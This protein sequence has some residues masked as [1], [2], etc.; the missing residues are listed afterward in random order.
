MGEGE[1]G[2]SNCAGSGQRADM[3]LNSYVLN[4]YVSEEQLRLPRTGADRLF[5]SVRLR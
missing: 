5:E 3:R 4:S 2:D 1:M